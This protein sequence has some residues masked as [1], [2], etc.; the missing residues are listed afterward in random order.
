MSKW[1]GSRARRWAI[2]ALAL[3]LPVTA[4]AI[5]PFPAAVVPNVYDYASYLFINNADCQ[6]NHSDLP[7]NIDCSSTGDFQTTN[8]RDTTR[9]D[10]SQN[11][12]EFYGVVGPST[13]M[14]WRITTGRPDVVIAV[15]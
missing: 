6:G 12:Q 2:A 4:I 14:A 8:Y 11:P 3:G 1:N 13:N 10:T 9:I 15:I 7:A 5:L